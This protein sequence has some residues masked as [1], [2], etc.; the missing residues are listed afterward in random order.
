MK[1]VVSFLVLILLVIAMLATTVSA[2]SSSELANK[3]Y[4]MGKPY[5]ATE[6]YK[7]RLQK[8][9]A[10]ADLTDAKAEKVLAIA[11]KAVDLM[12]TENVKDYTKLTD[13]KKEEMKNLVK[14]AAEVLG[15]TVV[16]KTEGKTPV[17]QILK[18]TKVVDE[19][20]YNPDTDELLLADTGSNNIALVVSSIVAVALVAGIAVKKF[21]N[22]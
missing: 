9:L 1:K 4:E 21:A 14:E 15:F 19:I 20:P 6:A 13:A 22:A 18:G 5:G 12:K 11:Q 8:D 10:A 7:A 16:F 3:L 2:M 17:I